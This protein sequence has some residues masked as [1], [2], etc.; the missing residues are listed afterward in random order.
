MVA[1]SRLWWRWRGVSGLDSTCSPAST[2]AACAW[3]RKVWQFH[4]L[5]YLQATHQCSFAVAMMVLFIAKNNIFI[6]LRFLTSPPWHGLSQLAMLCLQ[7]QVKNILI[8]QCGM[9]VTN[10]SSAVVV[11]A[12][13]VQKRDASSTLALSGLTWEK[14]WSM[15][16]MMQ[17]QQN[18]VMAVTGSLEEK[19]C[20]LKN[21]KQADIRTVKLQMPI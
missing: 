21:P 6:K 14:F 9:T 5:P 17:L 1:M 13:M 16:G 19:T 18:S 11:M 4:A 8:L 20:E 2:H 12:M 15:R 10:Q 7:C 3:W